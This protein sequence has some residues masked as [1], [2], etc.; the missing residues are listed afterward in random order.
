MTT[1]NPT[2]RVKRPLTEPEIG[3]II[4]GIER[5]T[6]SAELLGGALRNILN[7]LL[8]DIGASIDDFNADHRLRPSDYAIPASQW[9]AIMDAITG[10]AAEWGASVQVGL[11]LINVGPATYDDPDVPAPAIAIPDRRPTI[12]VLR[13]TREA[14]DVIGACV[15]HVADL[16]RFYG[17]H[18]DIHREALTSWHR[19][20]TGLFTM[21]MGADTHITVDGA[22]SLFV[23]CENG[24]VYGVIFHGQQ[25]HCTVNGC[26][27]TIRD[28]GT[29]EPAAHSTPDDHEHQPSYPPGAPQPGY[30]SVHS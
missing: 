6:N 28:D 14:V 11:E 2:Y 20:V 9:A 29:T 16:G 19:C 30:W 18:S 21:N 7:P 1:T 17:H 12:H 8:A 27:A 23:A 15:R 13:V 10:R 5:A 26:R 22:L 24:Y 3:D 25:R 4:A